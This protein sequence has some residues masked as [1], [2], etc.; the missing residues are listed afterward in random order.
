MKNRV[1]LVIVLCTWLAQ[2]Q[3]LAPFGEDR[4]QTPLDECKSLAVSAECSTSFAQ[5]FID[6]VTQCNS[7]GRSAAVEF[8]KK[9]RKNEAGKYCGQ[10]VN[11]VRNVETSCICPTECSNSLIKLV[12]QNGCCS[13]KFDS[14]QSNFSFCGVDFPSPCPPTSLN[15]PTSSSSDPSCTATN[16][17]I[18][19][20]TEFHCSPEYLPVLD[21]LDSNNCSDIV[22]ETEILCSKQDGEFCINELSDI[23]T[24]PAV[25]NAVQNCPST[26]NCSSSCGESLNNVSSNLGCCFHILGT[27]FVAKKSLSDASSPFSIISNN[28]L[29]QECGIP[30]PAVCPSSAAGNTV[31]SLLSLTLVVICNSFFV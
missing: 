9:C 25:L 22:Q 4:E 30:P 16:D 19:L 29:W 14:L 17:F 18:S 10:V 6:R 13:S 20:L 12:M 28:G 5:Y 15:I 8:E 23:L 3:C 27:S 2:T 24:S 7:L 21:S 11:N 26:K 31:L 1:Q